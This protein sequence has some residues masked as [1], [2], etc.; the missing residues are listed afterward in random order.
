MIKDK[1]KE[2][3]KIIEE[4]KLTNVYSPEDQIKMELERE[5]LEDSKKLFKEKIYSVEI[6]IH[7]YCN[8]TCTFCPLSREDVNRRDKKNTVYMTDEMYVSIMKQ[9]S[10]IDFDGR[11]DFTRYHEPLA[12]K[13]AILYRIRIAKKYI[14]K[15]KL[16]VNTNSDYLNKEY[17]QELLDAGIDNIA[18]QAYLRNGA[19]VYDEN[20][21]FERINQICDRIGAERIN[22]DEHKD[23]D[24]I[25]YRLPQFKGSIHARNYWKNGTNRAG[26]VPIDL[27]YRRTQPC[28]SM[29]KGVFIEYDGSMTICCD[30]ITPEVHKKWAVGNLSKQ[31]NLFL[32]YTSDYYT[33]WRTRINKA[34]WFKGSPCLVCKRDVRGKEA[35]V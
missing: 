30:M 19:T 3:I 1:N 35:R 32:N 31:P 28:T 14:P 33:E 8:R 25:I 9:L 21:V 23:K 22:P 4:N 12:D 27:G 24:W 15:A 34:D 20:E 26:S 29:N 16:N 7:S 10:E 17:L 18:M 5:Q 11:I 6:G 13:E 2:A